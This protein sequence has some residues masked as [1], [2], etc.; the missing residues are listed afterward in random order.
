[1]AASFYRPAIYCNTKGKAILKFIGADTA[2][3]SINSQVYSSLSLCSWTTASFEPCSL[4]TFMHGSSNSKFVIHAQFDFTLVQYCNIDHCKVVELH[5][6]THS[7][8]ERLLLLMPN[9]VTE[10]KIM[11]PIFGRP[12]VQV[13]PPPFKVSY[14]YRFPL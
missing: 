6:E 4:E 9:P 3:P 12:H 8:H 1:M 7:R 11:S 2:H 10:Q 5:L 14:T 13:A